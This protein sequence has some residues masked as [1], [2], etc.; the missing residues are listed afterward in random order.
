MSAYV[1]KLLEEAKGYSVKETEFFDTL[2]FGGGTPSLLPPPE[3]ERLVAGLFDSFNFAKDTEFTVEVNPGTLTERWM[4]TAA[5]LGVNRVSIGLQSIHENELKFL[6]RIHTFDDFLDSYNLLREAGFDNISVDLMYGI[7]EQTTE[8]FRATVE[9]VA[10]LSPEHISAY[11]LIVEEG[12]PFFDMKDT[13]PI[14][15]EDTEFDMYYLCDE[16]L[17][18]KRYKHYE[19]SNYARVGKESRHNLKYW[20]DSEYIGLGAAAYSYYGGRRY[21]NTRSLEEYLA[22][23]FTKVDVTPIDREDE[24]FEYAMMRLRLSQGIDLPEYYARFGS[25]FFEG[26]ESKI[27]RYISLGLMRQEGDSISLTTKGFYLSNSIL[28]DIL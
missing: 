12:T 3:L 26:R 28:S 20:T 7:P 13:L 1:D 19:I 25:S 23:P 11:G 10:S 17:S 9:K 8:S 16:L 2:Y 27:K 14:P 22:N 5:R 4:K 21:G 24:M 6:G 18:A 15:D